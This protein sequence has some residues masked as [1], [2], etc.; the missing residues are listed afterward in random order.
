MSVHSGMCPCAHIPTCTRLRGHSDGGKHIKK[1]RVPATHGAHIETH[2]VTVATVI[3]GG[4]S[5]ERFRTGQYQSVQRTNPQN[6]ALRPVHESR[7]MKTAEQPLGSAYFSKELSEG[8]RNDREQT[9]FIRI[10]CARVRS[11]GRAWSDPQ[12]VQLGPWGDGD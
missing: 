7:K 2:V 6:S 9:H 11:S 12:N 8:C 4:L 3:H 1:Q 5:A 10:Y